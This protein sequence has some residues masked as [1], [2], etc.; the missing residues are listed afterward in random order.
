MHDSDL[1]KSSQNSYRQESLLFFA[2]ASQSERECTM[3]TIDRPPGKALWDAESE[4]IQITAFFGLDEWREANIPVDGLPELSV[5]LRTYADR[6]G[7]WQKK[8]PSTKTVSRI[9]DLASAHRTSK[10]HC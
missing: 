1:V 7:D 6:V 2:F 10:S 9:S 5:R 8:Q 4:T 3:K